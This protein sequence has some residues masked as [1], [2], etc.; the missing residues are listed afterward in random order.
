M[1]IERKERRW[2]WRETS[3]EMD[4]KNAFHGETLRKKTAP[5]SIETCSFLLL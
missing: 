5:M 3:E 1:R 2:E 4:R